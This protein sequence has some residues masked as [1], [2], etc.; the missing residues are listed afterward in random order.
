MGGNVRGDEEEKVYGEGWEA[1]ISDARK[2]DCP[3]TGLQKQWW[4]NGYE[5]AGINFGYGKV[6]SIESKAN[7]TKKLIESIMLTND[8]KS[9]I[10]MQKEI[11]WRY[12]DLD[13]TLEALTKQLQE[14]ISKE[15]SKAV[16]RR[17]EALRG[18]MSNLQKVI[19]KIDL[20]FVL[21]IKG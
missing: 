13:S 20:D 12:R 19:G 8:L 3:Y 5:D 15:N 9:L 2:K 16:I 14:P 4:M 18:Q 11:G 17:V 7:K 10:A 21:K 1:R 6:E